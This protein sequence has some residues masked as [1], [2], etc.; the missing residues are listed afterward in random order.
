MT[1][2]TL[3]KTEY[4]QLKRQAEAYRKFASKFFEFAVKDSIEG[5]EKDFQ[6][7]DLYTQEFL[8]DLGSG[9]RKSSYD[10]KYANKTAKKRSR[11]IYQNA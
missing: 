4:E 11:T 7:S 6:D 1:K 2:V 5:V 3:P 8:R 10:K 9:L